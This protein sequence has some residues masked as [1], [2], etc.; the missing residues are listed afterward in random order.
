ME[1]GE[2]EARILKVLSEGGGLT[3][4]E[5]V[6]RLGW[7][8]D[9]RAVRRAVASLVRKGL[10]VK[11][12]DYGRGKVVLRAAGSSPGRSGGQPP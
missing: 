7:R 8:G 10:V 1:E 3:M 12:P 2:L 4:E 11:V 5:L 9:R 6:E